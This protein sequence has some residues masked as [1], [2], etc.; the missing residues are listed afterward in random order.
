MMGI[1]ARAG[2]RL[3]PEPIYLAAT[4]SLLAEEVRLRRVSR[5]AA[6]RWS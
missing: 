1:P 3:C 6:A 5:S 4:A 2:N